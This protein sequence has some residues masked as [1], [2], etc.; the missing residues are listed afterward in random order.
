MV[1]EDGRARQHARGKNPL[2]QWRMVV[3]GHHPGSLSREAFLRHQHMVKAKRAMPEDAT[4]GAVKRG[5]AWRSGVRRGGRGGRTLTVVSS[6]TNGR[7]PRSVCRGGRVD[8]GASSCLTLGARRVDQAVAPAGL[9][10]VQ[11]AG[12]HAAFEALEQGMAAHETPHQAVARALEQ[13]RDEAQR[14]RRPSDR[15]DPDHRLV[16]G[17]WARRWNEA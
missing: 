3:V 7:V 1:L 10:G 15:V 9:D 5:A 8:R 13:A 2:E 4:G 11:P 12:I 6:G 16:A 17:E 14:A